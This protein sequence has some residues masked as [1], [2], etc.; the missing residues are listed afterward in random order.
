MLVFVNK[1]KLKFSY[2]IHNETEYP[3]FIKLEKRFYVLLLWILLCEIWG[4]HGGEDH[5]D[6]LLDFG[7][8]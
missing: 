5:N 3:Y 2:K 6:I 4:F 1:G 8:V 7:A